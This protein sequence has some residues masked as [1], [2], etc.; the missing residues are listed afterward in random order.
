[1]VSLVLHKLSSETYKTFVEHFML[2]GYNR[3]YFSS[4]VEKVMAYWNKKI[5]AQTGEVQVTMNVGYL[6]KKP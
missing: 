6:L 1:M 4:L 2:Q 3:L 5:K